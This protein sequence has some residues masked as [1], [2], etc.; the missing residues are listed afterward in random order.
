MWFLPGQVPVHVGRTVTGTDGL[1]YSVPTDSSRDEFLASL[2]WQKAPD[3][4]L[5]KPKDDPEA[6]KSLLRYCLGHPL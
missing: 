6:L 1:S 2:G 4:P 3:K 5:T